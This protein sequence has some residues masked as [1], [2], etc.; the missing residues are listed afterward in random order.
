M[1]LNILQLLLGHPEIVP[2]F[3]YESL[4][5]LMSDFSVIGA[6][7]LNV[8]L[9]K[10]DVIR[11]GGEVEDAP[12]RRGHAVE[13]A[14]KQSPLLPQ[15]GWSLVR[16]EILDEDRDILDA[17]AEL[18]RQRIQSLFCNLDEIFAL[19][20]SPTAL[21]PNSRHLCLH[22]HHHL[23]CGHLRLLHLRLAVAAGAYRWVPPDQKG[24]SRGV[25]GVS[26]SCPNGT[27]CPLARA[28]GA[29]CGRWSATS[30]AVSLPENRTHIS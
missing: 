10:H 1:R 30:P 2:Q 12:L 20:P 26:C 4:A 22:R 7:R 5:D 6:D 3:M 27:L 14:Q 21:T 28:A 24:Q 17:A 25:A 29:I 16:R 18:I 15:L 9:V 19:H 11:S 13:D 23:L 8:L